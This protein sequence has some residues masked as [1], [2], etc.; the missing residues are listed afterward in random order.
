MRIHFTLEQHRPLEN[1]K[2]S[3]RPWVA[4]RRHNSRKQGQVGRPVVAALLL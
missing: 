3:Q 2:R 1:P 4:A